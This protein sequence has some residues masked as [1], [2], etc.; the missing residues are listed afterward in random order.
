MPD[1]QSLDTDGSACQA[2]AARGSEP[3]S[4]TRS[5]KPMK[6]GIQRMAKKAKGGKKK[7]GAKKR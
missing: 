1:A 5:T 4:R 7:A 3:D 6:G 2:A